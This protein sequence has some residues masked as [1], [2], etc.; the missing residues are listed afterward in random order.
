MDKSG[1][2]RSEWWSIGGPDS[3]TDKRVLSSRALQSGSTQTHTIDGLL[4]SDLGK[5]LLLLPNLENPFRGCRGCLIENHC[6]H[7]TL[8]R[9]ADLLGLVG[10]IGIRRMKVIVLCHAFRP[11]PVAESPVSSCCCLVH[12]HTE[13]SPVPKGGWVVELKRRDSGKNRKQ[14]CTAIQ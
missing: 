5:K 13:H 3:Q 10:F 7:R 2:E 1:V 8:R 6:F 12:T 14:Y 11:R 9:A 4:W